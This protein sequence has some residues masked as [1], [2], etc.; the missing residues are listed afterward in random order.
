M[1]EL[2]KS[3]KRGYNSENDIKAESKSLIKQIKAN[4]KKKEQAELELLEA[5]GLKNRLEKFG[6]KVKKT[7]EKC[8]E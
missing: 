8:K 3:V 2:F 4:M 5:G 1:P 6:N 7:L